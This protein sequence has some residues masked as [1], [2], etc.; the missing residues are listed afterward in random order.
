MLDEKTL[1]EKVNIINPDDFVLEC[2]TNMGGSAYITSNYSLLNTKVEV[3][4]NVSGI[5]M[6]RVITIGESEDNISVDNNSYIESISYNDSERKITIKW[7]L[8]LTS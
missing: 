1:I 4:C 8:R 5:E 3:V 2:T 6:T 7:T